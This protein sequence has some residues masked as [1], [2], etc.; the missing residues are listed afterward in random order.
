MAWID[1]QD[2]S[3]RRNDGA[4]SGLPDDMRSVLAA[5]LRLPVGVSGYSPGQQHDMHLK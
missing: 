4:T 2:G 5:G 3:V 1:A